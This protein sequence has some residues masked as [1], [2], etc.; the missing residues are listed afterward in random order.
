MHGQSHV[1]NH[2]ALM[3]LEMVSMES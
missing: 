2:W 3:S 1:Y